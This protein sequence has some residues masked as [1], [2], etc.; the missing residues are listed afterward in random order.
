[1]KPDRCPCCNS[2]IGT[3]IVKFSCEEYSDSKE[4]S[5]KE[6]EILKAAS[7]ITD[8]FI[9]LRFFRRTLAHSACVS[10][11]PCLECRRTRY[12]YV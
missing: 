6:Q 7:K 5:R 9:E 3:L 4:V 8:E 2:T 1:M 10:C 12:Y 11:C